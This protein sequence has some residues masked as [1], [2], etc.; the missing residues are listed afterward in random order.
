M[1]RVVG[2]G[3]VP[4]LWFH[5]TQSEARNANRSLYFEGD[6][7]YS[8]GRHFPIARHVAKGKDRAVL[9]TTRSY[10]VTTSGHCSA[11]RMAI[12][13]ATKVFNV[14]HLS[15]SQ[16]AHTDNLKDY[17]SRIE[18]LIS[19]VARARSSWTKEYRHREA[20]VLVQEVRDYA[21][22]FKVKLP[23]LPAVPAID[24]QE[25]AAIKERESKSAAKKAETTK[26]EKARQAEL[27]RTKVERWRNGENVGNLWNI[28]VMLRIRTFGADE[29]AAGAVGRVET[30]LGAQIPITH[31]LRG[32][33][34][35][36]AVMSRGEAYQK[37]GHT[38]Y[39]GPYAV[40]KIDVDGTL[41]VGCHVI[42][43][44]EIERIAP[45]LE[46]F[47]GVQP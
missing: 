34:F 26:L 15:D 1:K 33:V 42:S 12:P 6:T 11:V 13:A 35:V 9:F 21:K 20:V 4:H 5:A 14:P 47:A 30:S 7:I 39:L 8:Y 2:S 3:E 16:L 17:L 27:E 45:E 46:K 28:P 36:R 43:W 23:K 18:K 29:S 24:S 41:H 44:A 37:N 40:N 25:M 22:F 38:L 10:S 19:V 32:L 31:A